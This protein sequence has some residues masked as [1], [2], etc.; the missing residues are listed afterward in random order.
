MASIL[1][2]LFL[3]ALIFV[4]HA[5]TWAVGDFERSHYGFLKKLGVGYAVI[6]IGVYIA[7][8]DAEQFIWFVALMGTW[9]GLIVLGWFGRYRFKRGLSPPF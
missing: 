8:L 9:A 1:G 5:G 4:F 6:A 7:Y 3:G 2:P